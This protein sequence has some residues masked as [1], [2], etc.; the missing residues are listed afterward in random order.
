MPATATIRDLR[1]HFP[2]IRKLVETEGEV[3]LSDSGHAKYRL[4]LHSEPPA[5]T[6]PPVDYWARLTA[7]Q[8]VAL[9]A[10]QSRALHDDNRG[11][12]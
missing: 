3:I 12:R 10:A 1:N 5:K 11:D 4:T 7:Q 9:T 2:K 8:P 6:T